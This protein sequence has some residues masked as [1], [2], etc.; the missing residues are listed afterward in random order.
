MAR[1][2]RENTRLEEE[3]A[4]LKKAAV[5]F[6]KPFRLYNALNKSNENPFLIGLM[7]RFYRFNVVVTS[8]FGKGG[9]RGIYLIK[10]P[11][12]TLFQRGVL[13]SYVRIA[14]SVIQS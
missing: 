3:M 1:L 13:N 2:K 10:Y 8:T 4:F 11:L 14:R 6:A 12:T 5:Y 9:L 7:C